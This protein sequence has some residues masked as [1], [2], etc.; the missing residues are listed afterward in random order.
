MN[1]GLFLTPDELADLTERKTRPAQAAWL[2]ARGIPFE[3]G[4]SG[5]PIGV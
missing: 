1:G 5:R 4:A 2:Q 3:V